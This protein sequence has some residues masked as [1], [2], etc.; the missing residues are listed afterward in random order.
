MDAPTYPP[1]AVYEAPERIAEPLNTANGSF[2][3]FIANPQA[4]ALLTAA[5]PEMKMMMGTPM[6]KPHLG[7]M[8]PRSLIQYGGL[9]PE[10]LDTVDAQ[11][12]A[13]SIMIGAK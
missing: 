6:L 11:L 5:V 9:H 2:E 8:S 3:D 12:K 1:S 10:R 13:L 4:L 7:N